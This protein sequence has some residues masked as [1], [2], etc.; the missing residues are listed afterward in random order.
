MYDKKIDC[1]SNLDD[2]FFFFSDF[3]HHDDL[4]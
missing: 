2:W 3:F 1:Y 4:S